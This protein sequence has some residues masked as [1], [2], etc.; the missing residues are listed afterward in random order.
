MDDPWGLNEPPAPHP[1]PPE[2][3]PPQLAKLAALTTPHVVAEG[4]DW[5]SPGP[6]ALPEVAALLAEGW[7]LLEGDGRYAFLPAIW[8]PELRC[9]LPNRLPQVSG[10]FD[11]QTSMVFPADQSPHRETHRMMDSD[12]ETDLAAE[13][14]L[15]VPPPGRIWLLKSPWPWLGLQVVLGLFVHRAAE[16]DLYEP[17]AVMA[18]ASEMLQW[19][20]AQLLAWWT[21]EDADAALAWQQQGRVGA[22]A[23]ELIRAGI[24]PDQL[25]RMAKLTQKQAVEWCRA[26]AGRNVQDAVDRVVFFRS[27]GFPE[28]PPENLYRLGDLTIDDIGAWFAAGFDVPS[29]VELIGL[30][31]HQ[32]SLW[33]EYGHTPAQTR[34]L[35]EAD[36]TLTV[37][38]ADAF[39]AVGI[40]GSHQMEWI[41]HGFGPAE[42][43]GYDELDI[44][45]NEARVWRSMGL[46]P[47]DAQPGQY[48][49]DGYQLNGWSIAADMRMRDAQY[50][51]PDPPGTRGQVTA[52]SL[53][54]LEYHRK[55]PLRPSALD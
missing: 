11:G 21:G 48:M 16:E 2:P 23:A 28:T 53:E 5:D 12:G 38:E 37:A 46:G 29:M 32:A 36:P 51:V 52:Q 4:E 55:H 30:T 45:P 47:W 43:T 41:R 10:S 3:L 50:Q 6:Q 13:V 7:G 27:V 25:A 18:A 35:L 26:V 9:W 14:G 15:P 22:D 40:V 44:Q 33:R 17:P 42:A 24:G 19:D 20:E 49:P 8:P 1:D 39:A 31:L 54:E 34:A